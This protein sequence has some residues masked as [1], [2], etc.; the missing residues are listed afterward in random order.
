[1]ISIDVGAGVPAQQEGPELSV[2]ATNEDRTVA[3]VVVQNDF[4]VTQA[5]CVAQ[6][7]S[8][9]RDEY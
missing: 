1:M 4:S 9:L 2:E 5:D 7:E 3:A 6:V 8:A